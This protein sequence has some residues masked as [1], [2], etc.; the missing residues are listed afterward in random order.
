MPRGVTAVEQSQ[1]NGRAEQRVRA[2]R[3]R[4][5]MMVEDARRRGVAR[6]AM[7]HAEEQSKSLHMKHTQETKA[8]SNV[9][10]FWERILVGNKNDD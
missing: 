2:L 8:P 9:A 1:A 10:G 6:W 7:R 5:R 3:E 4:L